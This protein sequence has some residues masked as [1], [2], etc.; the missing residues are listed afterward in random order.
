RDRAVLRGGAVGEVEHH[1][2]D[3][4]PTPALGRVVAFDDRMTRIMKAPRGVA[5]WRLVA[6]PDVA[7]RPAQTQMQPFRAGL[8]TL[9]ATE[10]AWR[11][12]ANIGDMGAFVGHCRP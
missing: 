9:L 1:L 10:R 4:T 3:V 5:V 6:T 12:H 2:V 8:Q 7:A 11:D